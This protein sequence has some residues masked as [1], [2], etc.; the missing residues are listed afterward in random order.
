VPEGMTARARH[1]EGWLGAEL[2]REALYWEFT[3]AHLAAID[4]L[5]AKIEAAGIPFH[6]IRRQHFSHPALD[7][8]LAAL[9]AHI[10]SG[11]GLVIMRAFPVDKY[12]AERMQAVYW[13][14]GTHFGHGCSQSADGDYLGYVTNVEKASRGY[15]TDRELNLH[16][17]SAEIVGLLC[18]RDAREGGLSLYASSLKVHEIIAR[19]HP[20]YLPVLERGF[21]CDRRGEE[22]PEDEPVTPYRVPVF[23]TEGGLLSCRYVRGVIDKGAATLGEPLT[24]FDK[25]ALACFEEVAQR[26]D[27]RFEVMLRPGEASVIDNYEILHARTGFVD[28]EEPAKKRL[29]Y[30]LWLEGEPPRPMRREVHLY[31]NRSGHMGVD[32]QPG[33]GPR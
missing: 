1:R 7:A 33:R 23:S 8:D 24:D 30:R 9:L 19:E 5:M 10:K 27:V 14:I 29:L 26:D 32:P 13:G 31:Q 28:W 2:D 17:D 16:T 11:P 6:E 12:D 21:R 22:A 20:E 4:E 18:V 3:P 25:E 15:T